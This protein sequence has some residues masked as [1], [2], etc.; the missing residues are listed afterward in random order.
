LV[1]EDVLCES[2]L[3][4]ARSFQLKQVERRAV[5]AAFADQP[6]PEY[7]ARLALMSFRAAAAGGFDLADATEGM[8]K[9][10]VAV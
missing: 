7:P 4:T 2:Q 10:P 8:E 3:P 9:L 5:C 6:L 1:P